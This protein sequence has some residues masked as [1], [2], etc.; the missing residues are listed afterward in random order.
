MSEELLMNKID[1][2]TS[3]FNE[4]KSG[5]GLRLE[6]VEK[7]AI[8]HCGEIKVLTSQMTLMLKIGWLIFATSCS[9]IV[10]AAM[11]LLIKR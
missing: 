7:H 8:D 10:I 6:K 2:L 4:F 5:I 11:N 3:G 1:N 9:V